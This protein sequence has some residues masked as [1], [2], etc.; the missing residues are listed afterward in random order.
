MVSTTL[1]KPNRVRIYTG[2]SQLGKPEKKRWEK[3]WGRVVE[4]P[5][6][7]ESLKSS[8]IVSPSLVLRE[9]VLNLLYLPKGTSLKRS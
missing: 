4:E 2:L 3:L 9:K 7:K 5:D 1:P 8:K 6:E